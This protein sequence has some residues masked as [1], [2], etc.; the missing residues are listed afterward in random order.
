M[1]YW[2]RMEKN[3]WTD[4]VRNEYALQTAKEETKHPTYYTT[5]EAI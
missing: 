5:K 2:K 3:S 4:H 1:W